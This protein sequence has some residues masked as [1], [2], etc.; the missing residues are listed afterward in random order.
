MAFDPE[1]L[2]RE[3]VYV[4]KICQQPRARTLHSNLKIGADQVGR[5]AEG[6]VNLGLGT[7]RAAP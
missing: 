5:L 3:P 2:V 4:D 7:P 1:W 6:A